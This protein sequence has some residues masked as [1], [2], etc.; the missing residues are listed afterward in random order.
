MIVYT[1]MEHIIQCHLD[2]I[3][4]LAVREGS[5][6]WALLGWNLVDR[7]DS[8][9]LAGLQK[10]GSCE[11]RPVSPMKLGGVGRVVLFNG[12]TYLCGT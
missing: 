10:D 4:G 6:D 11:M 2:R 3:S 1:Y 8:L 5:G 7:V 9:F 12:N